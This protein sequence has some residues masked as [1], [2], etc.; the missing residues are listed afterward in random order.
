MFDTYCFYQRTMD[1]SQNV[2]IKIY[3][4]IWC[5]I[6]NLLTRYPRMQSIEV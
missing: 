6:L 1:D 5:I 4:G 2:S 3:V